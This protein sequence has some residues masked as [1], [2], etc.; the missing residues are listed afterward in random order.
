MLT[1]LEQILTSLELV[2]FEG[3]RKVE[4]AAQRSCDFLLW[5]Y[6]KPSWTLPSATCFRGT[7]VSRGLGLGDLQKSLPNPLIL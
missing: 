4:Q 1:S 2:Y 6:S 3:D 7:C 5:R